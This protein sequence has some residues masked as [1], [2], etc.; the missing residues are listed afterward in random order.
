L[1]LSIGIKVEH[2]FGPVHQT[3]GR[4][5]L[6]FAA[7]G[8]V[9][10][11]AAHPRAKDVQFRFAHR[12]LQSQQQ[13]IVETRRIVRSVMLVPSFADVRFEVEMADFA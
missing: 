3:H 1:H 9:D 13:A 8:F 6:Q 10:L 7:P 5:D 11:A 2:P 12:S 4:F